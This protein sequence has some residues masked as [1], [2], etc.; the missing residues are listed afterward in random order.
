MKRFR[1]CRQPSDKGRSIDSLPLEAGAVHSSRVPDID[2]GLLP[3]VCALCAPGVVLACVTYDRPQKK[4]R[5]K[6]GSGRL[7]TNLQD[8][9]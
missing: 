6:V 1:V 7:Q 5:D 3:L 8:A 9:S 4:D 2:R